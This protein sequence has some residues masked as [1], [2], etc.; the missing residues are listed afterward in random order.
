MFSGATSAAN[1]S[2]VRVSGH[3]AACG[4]A[5]CRVRV[6]ERESA[7]EF[8][9]FDKTS[10]KVVEWFSDCIAITPYR[11]A[12][13]EGLQP[14]TVINRNCVHNPPSVSV[15]RLANGLFLFRADCA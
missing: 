2:F 11:C 5:P 3:R 9:L 14:I 8:F 13:P 7:L 10:A 12:A 4:R 1:C 15:A 6:T